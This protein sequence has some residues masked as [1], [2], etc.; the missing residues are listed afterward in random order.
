MRLVVSLLILLNLAYF[1]WSM[2]RDYEQHAAVQ[3]EPGRDA[4]KLLEDNG[5]DTMRVPQKPQP[6][7]PAADAPSTAIAVEC[8][9]LGP[10][11]S[12]VS[13]ERIAQELNLRGVGFTRRVEQ[14]RNAEEYW[15]YIPPAA[16]REAALEVSRNLAER[17]VKDYY[18]V[19]VDE[20]RNA[21]S[22]GLFSEMEAATR[23][24]DEISRSGYEATTDIRYEEATAYWLDVNSEGSDKLLD[25]SLQIFLNQ[26]SVKPVALACEQDNPNLRP[27]ARAEVK[28]DSQKR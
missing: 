9:A 27:D 2:L 23:R 15:V 6:P 28:S 21:I 25:S 5:G 17:G 13:L 3:S 1:S 20:K 26:V 18:V 22:L 4:V 19:S 16:S 14:G 11:K 8:Y 12:L 10:F 7:K 24:K